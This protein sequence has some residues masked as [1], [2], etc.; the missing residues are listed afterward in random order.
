MAILKPEGVIARDELH[1]L[2]FA[3]LLSFI[4][5]IPV[6][7]LLVF[8][9]FRYRDSNKKSKYSPNYSNRLLE[10]VWWLI[11]AI[12][13]TILSVVTWYS[14]H[15]LDPSKRLDSSNAPVR[16]QVVALNWKWLFI[17][18]DYGIASV[19]DLTVPIN[20]PLD[21]SITSAGAMNSFWVPQLGGQIY[22]MAGMNTALHLMADKIGVYRG[23]SANISGAGFAG[24][25]FDLHA[26]NQNDFRNWESNVSQS[27]DA[28]TLSTFDELAKPTQDVAPFIYGSVESGLFDTIVNRNM[29]FQPDPDAMMGSMMNQSGATE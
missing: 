17:Y 25:H 28:L 23:V 1:L 12:I 14:T 20:Q 6:F 5:I 21:F 8:I 13:I 3:T 15:R 4:V 2:K 11:P 22:A 29:P 16:V 24:M 19:N 27:G 18:P 10:I 7:S 26:V 9:V